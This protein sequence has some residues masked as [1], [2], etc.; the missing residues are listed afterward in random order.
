MTQDDVEQRA[1]AIRAALM[2][3]ETDET[4]VVRLGTTVQAVRVIRK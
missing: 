1:A 2:R 3:G 4:I